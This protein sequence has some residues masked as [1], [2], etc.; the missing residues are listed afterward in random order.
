MKD[1]FVKVACASPRLRVADPAYNADE[2]LRLIEA[3]A[4][5]C[6]SVLVLPELALTGKTC[7]DLFLQKRLIDECEAQIGRIV[8]ATASGSVAVVLGAPVAIS[9]KLYNAALVAADG[10]LVGV[11]PKSVLSPEEERCLSVYRGDA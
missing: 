6:V 5:Q 11:V 1:G 10:K 2:I 3:A 8:A 4:E 7:G 9:D